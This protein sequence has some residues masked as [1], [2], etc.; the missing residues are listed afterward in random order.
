MD[1]MLVMRKIL[2]KKMVAKYYTSEKEGLK[3]E[4][5]SWEMKAAV[6]VSFREDFFHCLTHKFGYSRKSAWLGGEKMKVKNR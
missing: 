5:K 6:S 4:K 2:S 1:T 3:T